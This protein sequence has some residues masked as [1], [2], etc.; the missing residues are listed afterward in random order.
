MNDPLLSA[1][2]AVL[3]AIAA[4]TLA[5]L[6]TSVRLLPEVVDASIILTGSGLG[7]LTF[8]AYGALRRFDPQR[9]ARLTVGGTVL[10]GL[11]GAAGFTIALLVDVL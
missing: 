7:A 4:A 5:A 6:A 1:V 8:T 10:G 2:C 9:I 11:A 3:G